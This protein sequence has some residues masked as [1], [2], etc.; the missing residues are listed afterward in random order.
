MDAD[1]MARIQ[2]NRFDADGWIRAM[3]EAEGVPAWLL[4]MDHSCF[5]K[6][7]QSGDLP[8]I[9]ELYRSRTK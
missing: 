8:R 5:L 7:V 2:A 4:D 9:L 1:F 3:L 6:I